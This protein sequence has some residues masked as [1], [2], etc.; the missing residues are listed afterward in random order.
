MF[1]SFWQFRWGELH[2][3]E[4][5]ACIFFVPPR[6]PSCTVLRLVWSRRRRRQEETQGDGR[7]FPCDWQSG[8]DT[9]CVITGWL[10]FSEQLPTGVLFCWG[11]LSTAKCDTHC[12]PGTTCTSHIVV[13][14][15]RQLCLV[16]AQHHFIT[17]QNVVT[18]K[19]KCS[20][21]LQTSYNCS[22]W[23]RVMIWKNL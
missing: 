15:Y 23:E 11:C 6:P 17:R 16:L 10:R 12:Y 2:G 3:E 4:V 1:V 20:W 9:G 21:K 14:N 22:F 18:T 13:C 8:L 19:K 7:K 5:S